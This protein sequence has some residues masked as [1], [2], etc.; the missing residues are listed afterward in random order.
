MQSPPHTNMHP[1]RR[2]P[3]KVFVMTGPATSGIVAHKT[4]FGGKDTYRGYSWD[5]LQKLM[6]NPTLSKKYDFHITYS[7]SGFANYEK[8][9]K[10]IEDG[11]YDIAIGGFLQT[12]TREKKV[13]FSTPNKIDSNAIFHTGSD[14]MYGAA[15]TTIQ[16]I[17]GI[18]IAIFLMGVLLGLVLYFGNPGRMR[19]LGVANKK[20]FF[21]SSMIAGIASMFGEFGYIAEKATLS[22]KGL[23][24]ATFIMVIASIALLYVQA[25]LTAALVEEKINDNLSQYTLSKGVVLGHE[26]YAVAEKLQAE[27]VNVKFVKG[28]TNDQ[29][30]ELYLNNTDKYDGVVLSY[31]DG[32]PYLKLHPEL[33]AS[34]GFGHEPSGF[35][36]R[37]T[38]R[39]FLDDVNT[40]IL[41]MRSDGTLKA[42]CNEYFGQMSYADNFPTCSLS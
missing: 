11:T 9:I 26:G 42:L 25:K 30:L 1:I 13:D 5:I 10:D 32:Y 21:F 8:V 23:F 31:C 15:I 3:I 34:I 20:D 14:S 41:E 36:V 40:T 12:F 24:I 19:T 39:E 16:S 38:Q 22:Y 28:Y 35:P 18:L 29:L 33:T 7:E 6:K 4:S 37:E 17:G 27:G 2:K